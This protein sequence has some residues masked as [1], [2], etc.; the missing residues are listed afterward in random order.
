MKKPEG[1]NPNLD[2]RQELCIKEEVSPIHFL[3]DK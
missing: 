3:L 1:K 2:R